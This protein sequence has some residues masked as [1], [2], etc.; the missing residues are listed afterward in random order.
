MMGARLVDFIAEE[1]QQKFSE[2][3]KTVA[4]T[5]STATL[6]LPVVRKD[7]ISVDLL[8]SIAW[9]STDNS[10]F[11]ITHDISEPKRAERVQQELVQMVSHDLRSPLVAISGFHEFAE[12]GVL[13]PLNENGIRQIASARR[14]TG[15]M[16]TLACL[17]LR[18]KEFRLHLSLR[19][20]F[21]S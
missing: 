10:I 12:R 6:E 7:R 19:A 9:S 17:K 8:W 20:H 13:G 2:T 3:L 15:Q 1:Y 14:S 21:K 18:E 11:C 16:L 5:R 4:D